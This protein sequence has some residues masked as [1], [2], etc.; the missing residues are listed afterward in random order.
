MS[1]LKQAGLPGNRAIPMSADARIAIPNS[2][3]LVDIVE[4]S[5]DRQPM[6]SDG[7]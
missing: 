3:H 6:N 7:P 1:T 2:P 5:S 4:N